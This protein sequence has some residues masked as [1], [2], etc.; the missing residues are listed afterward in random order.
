M[1]QA[2]A[3]WP[4]P[5]RQLTR[6]RCTH[7][8]PHPPTHPQD[9]MERYF[10]QPLPAKMADVRPHLAYQARGRRATGAGSRATGGHT[11][12]RIQAPMLH[13][14]RPKPWTGGRHA[15]G[16][17]EAEVPA[18]RGAA[19]ARCQPGGRGRA[20]HT[21]TGRREV[22]SRRHC[23]RERG[24]ARAV[25]RLQPGL[26][27]S[28][29]GLCDPSRCLAPGGSSG[30]WAPPT[31]R[32]PH[33][34]GRGPA[35]AGLGRVGPHQR[36]QQAHV[37]RWPAHVACR[38]RSPALQFP[39]LNAEPVVPAAFPEWQHV[40]D[41][42]GGALGRAWAAP[43]CCG[44]AGRSACLHAVWL[45]PT[46]P[47]TVACAPAQ[48]RCWA[49]WA[50]WL[51]WQ[52]AGLACSLAPSPRA[53][54]VR[55]TCWRPP[56]PTSPSTASWAPCMRASTV[57]GRALGAAGGC[58]AG[59]RAGRGGPCRRGFGAHALPLILPSYPPTITRRRPQLP[60]HPW[61]LP[62]PRPLRLAGQRPPHPGAQRTGAPGTARTPR[63]RCATLLPAAAARALPPWALTL[64]LA[65]LCLQVRIP[66]GC[67]LLQAGKQLEWLTGGAVRAGFHEVRAAVSVPGPPQHCTPCRG[68]ASAT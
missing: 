2:A 65:C 66:E 68:R 33:R 55:R 4:A 28:A 29:P 40:M 22:V 36:A 8:H 57:S 31:A 21:Y 9:L 41:G 45:P 43:C 48:T 19:A 5:K 38:V 6:N 51:R 35:A 62:L 3:S 14:R 24:R 10:D 61:P 58:S 13:R 23:Q 49:R 34:R 46:R 50:R 67:L 53:W 54:R 52:H 37:Q 15:R 18:R 32:A 64:S 25:A 11:R 27:S 20:R 12:S 30:G 7:T 17:R 42:W 44:R 63:Q 1:Q 56:A 39:E 60:H 16:C 47:R 26:S 59:A